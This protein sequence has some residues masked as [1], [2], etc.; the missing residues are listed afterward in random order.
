MSELFPDE[1]F[2]DRTQSDSKRL[3]SFES[4][5]KF[6]SSCGVFQ[7][8]VLDFG[9]S[10]GEFLTT[11]NWPGK[12]Y[13]IEINALASEIAESNGVQIVESI[14]EAPKS[15]K[16][17]VFRGVI[18]HLKSPFELIEEVYDFLP[19]GGFLCFLA[20][21]NSNSIV[22]KLSCDLPALDKARVFW[23]T[24]D[25]QLEEVCKNAGFT[26]YA[27]RYPYRESG[28]ASFTDF[29]RFLVF[30]ILPKRPRFAFPKNMVDIIFQKS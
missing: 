22:Y 21:P 4:E 29:L 10:T 13:G 20:T 16:T 30:L 11:T 18:Q 19:E 12:W 8:D 23:T 28:Y 26:K 3:K 2:N 15:V 25:T 6:L 27:V 5:K 1:Y 9:C 24:S 17:V 14:S 7:D